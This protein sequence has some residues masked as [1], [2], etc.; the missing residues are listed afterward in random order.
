MD[1]QATVT[2]WVRHHRLHAR[3]PVLLLPA[4]S[5]Y[6][7]VRFAPF[8]PALQGFAYANEAGRM[9]AINAALSLAEQRMVLAHE[10]AHLLC[11]DPNSLDLCQDQDDWLYQRYECEAQRHAAYILIPDQPLLRLLDAHC[12]QAQLAAFFV[13]PP[14]LINLRLLALNDPLRGLGGVCH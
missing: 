5:S 13:V 1:A 14:S 4:V 10:V 3:C 7:E 8:S 2:R 12:D 6:A 11:G 9:V